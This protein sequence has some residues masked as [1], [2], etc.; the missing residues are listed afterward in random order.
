MQTQLFTG[1]DLR[2]KGIKVAI[3]NVN[4]KVPNWSEIAYG[5]LIGYIRF[6]RE[7]MAEDC[8]E[9]SKGIVP[10]PPSKRA[11]GAV[12]VRAKIEGLIKSVGF[13]NVT[14]AKAHRTPASVW[15]RI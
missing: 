15:Q 6:H 1:A 13:R 11:W 5:F 8:R 4:T 9:A 2:D 10:E 12:I 7:F 3:T 14:N